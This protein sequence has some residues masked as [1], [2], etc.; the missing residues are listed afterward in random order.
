M[1][2]VQYVLSAN[3]L[4]AYRQWTDLLSQEELRLSSEFNVAI[5]PNKS[6]IYPIVYRHILDTHIFIDANTLFQTIEFLC[7]SIILVRKKFSL[8]NVTLPHSWLDNMF[9]VLDI[10]NLSSELTQPIDA[11]LNTFVGSMRGLM[12]SLF[13]EEQHT[14]KILLIYLEQL[15]C[16]SQH[17]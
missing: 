6:I 1:A 10:S 16:F 5:Y 14:S 17:H 15:S 8:H 9:R 2:T 3:F 11:L 4:V 12:H 7:G 13:T